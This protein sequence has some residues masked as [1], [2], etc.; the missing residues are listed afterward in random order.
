MR[1]LPPTL[2]L[3]AAFAP[4]SRAW[5]A[6][7]HEIVATIAQIHLHPSVYPTLCT[8]LN[9]TSPNFPNEPQCHL[10]PVAAWADK[11][12]YKM[13]W[14]ASLHYVGA[15]G[16]HP[17]DTCL[18]PG[19]RGWEGRRGANVLSGLRNV[20]NFLTGFEVVDGEDTDVDAANEAL[21]F[22]IHF[23]GDLHMPL[24]LTG[25]DKGG[26]SDKVLFDGR[27]TNL[28]SLWDGLLI[29]KAI[30]S[31]P[32]KYHQPLP[33]ERIEYSLRGA[34]Y[35]PYI[36]QIMSE[37]VLGDWASEIPEW[38]SCPAAPE[39]L[40][41][42][43]GLQRVFSWL[44]GSGARRDSGEETDDDELCPYSW[45]K[46]IHAL[47]CEIVWPKELD[48]ESMSRDLQSEDEE[49]LSMSSVEEE[50][51]LVDE[52]GRFVGG[53][54][55]KKPGLEL[56]T[57]EYAGEIAKRRLVEKLLAQAGIRLAAMLNRLFA[58]EG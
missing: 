28:H 55:P 44:T 8:I 4:T 39:P 47:N 36:R 31:V 57:P 5:G 22:M 35:D 19:V 10:A 1:L 56:D 41:Q 27:Q 3:V 7:G 54:L 12:R 38:L 37:G 24:H 17:P 23:M 21:K 26:N 9:F 30:R 13:H 42:D 40:A 11:I 48:D 16:D 25:R 14:S 52:A 43:T 6:A 20:T 32:R 45:A 51:A 18:F 15:L 33:D 2:L 58:E 50:M 49:Q 29:A 53:R 46:P 34:I